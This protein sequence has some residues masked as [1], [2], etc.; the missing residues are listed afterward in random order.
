M[1]RVVVVDHGS[2]GSA[3]AAAKLGATVVRD[4]GN[5]G[6]GAGQDRG[7]ELTTAPYLLLCN[8]DAV[9]EPAAIASGVA[10]FSTQPELAALQGVIR[11]RDRDLDQRSSWQS[12]GAPH[13]WAR[14]VRVGRLLRTRPV[15]GLA[16]RLGLTPRAP[17]AAHD[18]EALAAI[19]LLVRRE[20]LEGV[21]GFDPG[22]FLY[23]EDL[24]LS[25]RLRDAGWRL[26]VTPEL[27]A[28][29][30]GG[31]SS[32]DAFE[33]EHQWWRGCMR[34]AALWYPAGEWLAALGAA[35]VQWFT[36]AVTRPSEAR[37]LWEDLVTS[38]RRVRR[39]ASRHIR[40]GPGSG[41]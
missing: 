15:R 17:A 19:V 8:P 9:V 27:W 31:A 26:A 20:A 40:R 13:L 41:G 32:G 33:R 2:D 6:Y 34:Y 18:V 38:P 37:L 22:Y 29:H 11:E 16:N 21:G 4:P 12:V 7:R 25:K 14:I 36:M 30:V 39:G 3:D 35:S 5:P 10:A 23:W 28:V 24:D 1:G